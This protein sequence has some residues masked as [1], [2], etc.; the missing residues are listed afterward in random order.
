MKEKPLIK[1]ILFSFGVTAG[2]ALLL[3]GLAHIAFNTNF[4]G[5]F[6]VIFVAQ[7]VLFY[8][9]NT[10]LAQISANKAIRDA[11]KIQA[12]AIDAALATQSLSLD[13]AYCNTT[14]I[15]P[16]VISQENI[17][18]CISCNSSNAVMMNFFAARVTNPVARKVE[19]ELQMGGLPDEI[20]EVVEER[21]EAIK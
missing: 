11:A 15:V 3:A 2:I 9:L 7:F 14:N 17:F 8:I 6:G 20:R 1:Q 13:C 19:T 12:D 4:W 18:K 10:V 21:E 5:W 16:V